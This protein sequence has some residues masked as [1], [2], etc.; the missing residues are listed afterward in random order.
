MVPIYKGKGKR[1]EC[2]NYRPISL[3]SSVSKVME[4]FIC[5][6]LVN[7]CDTNN[8]ISDVQHGFRSKLSTQSNMLEMCNLM[9]NN[10]ECGNNAELITIDLCKAFDSIPHNKLIHKLSK[11]CIIGKTLNW[12]SSFLNNK[13]F[14]VRLKSEYSNPY[15]L[16]SSVPQ[17]LYLSSYLY[18]AYYL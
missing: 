5:Q 9:V 4:T 11:Y 17:G 10:I 15:P 3:T 1:S 2:S 16:L 14:N 13:V 12:I 6:H 7:Y 8:L 18:V